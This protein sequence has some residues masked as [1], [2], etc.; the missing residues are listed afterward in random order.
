M[1]Q[2][3]TEVQRSFILISFNTSV[4]NGTMTLEEDRSGGVPSSCRTNKLV[5]LSLSCRVNS[6]IT[7]VLELTASSKWNVIVPSS[8]SKSKL[9]IEGRFSS[10]ITFE[11]TSGGITVAG[12]PSLSVKASDV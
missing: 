2:L 8:R 7:I 9:I 4:V 5:T 6:R 11:A 3:I 12:F 10:K 1:K